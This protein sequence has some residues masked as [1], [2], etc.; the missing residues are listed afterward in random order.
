[1]QCYL[2]RMQHNLCA[3]LFCMTLAT[4]TVKRVFDHR[5]KSI[6][7]YLRLE[8]ALLQLQTA[9]RGIQQKRTAH[10]EKAVSGEYIHD[11]STK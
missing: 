5:M 3:K 6:S 10:K 8:P 11:F 1:M 7:G 4:K 2:A 9:D